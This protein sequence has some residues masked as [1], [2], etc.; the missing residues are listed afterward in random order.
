MSQDFDI[1]EFQQR[2][3]AEFRDNG[4]KLGG[5]FEGW[6]LVLLNTA[7]ARSGLVRTALLGYL[8]IDGN[9]VVVASAMGAPNNPAWYHNI[10]QNPMVTVETGTETYEAIAALPQGAERDDLF[11]KVLD[12]APGF[13]DHQAKTTREIPVVV[14]HRVAPEPG[15]ERVKGMGEWLVEVHDW[16]RGDLA[17]LRRQVDKIADGSQD[18]LERTPPGLGQELRAH[19]LNFCGALK[20]HHTGEDMATFPMLAR[21]FP[22]LAPALAKLGE[23]HV[24]VARLQTEIQQLVDDYVPGE[25]DPARLREDL[26]RLASQLEAHFEYEERTVVTALNAVAAAPSFG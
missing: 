8:E 26:D 1:A 15:A 18:S 20:R 10:R 23:E 9:P 5:M 25:S 14:L 3:I 2:L 6:R 22:A 13:A 7:G 4:G 17:D 21:Q 19:C 16:L 11:G 24:I 12:Q